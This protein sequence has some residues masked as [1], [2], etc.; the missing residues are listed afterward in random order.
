MKK[1]LIH[2]SYLSCLA[3][4]ITVDFFIGMIF[5]MIQTYHSLDIFTT[6]FVVSAI[7]TTPPALISGGMM[8][9]FNKKFS[10]PKVLEYIVIFLASILILAISSRDI[11]GFF[12]SLIFDELNSEGGFLPKIFTAILLV[13]TTLLKT[14]LD[15][16]KKHLNP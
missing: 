11:K 10:L 14:I 8:I 1:F 5:Y 13:K 3:G 12:L 6:A 2:H 16:S 7:V 15:F 4:N 9:L